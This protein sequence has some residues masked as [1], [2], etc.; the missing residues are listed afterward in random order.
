LATLTSQ[1]ERLNYILRRP[2]ELLLVFATKG[3]RHLI[4]AAFDKTL[5]GVEDLW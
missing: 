3:H 4:A 2:Q 1:A 5:Q